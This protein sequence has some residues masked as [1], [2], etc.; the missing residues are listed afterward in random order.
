MDSFASQ[1]TNTLGCLLGT[2]LLAGLVADRFHFPK[3]TAYLLVGLAAGP[4]MLNWLPPDHIHAFDTTT[5]LAMALVLFNLGCHFPLT[6][7]RRV[8]RRSMIMSFGELTATF[9][10][11]LLSL[12]AIGQSWGVALLLASLALA[13]APATTILVLKESASQGPVTEHANTLV[14]LNNLAAIVIFEVVFIAI[15]MAIGDLA[16][17]LSTEIGLLFRDVL[18]SVVLGMAA[19][20]VISFGCGLLSTSRWLVL[21]IAAT[22]VVLGCCE[23]LDMPYMLSF[24]TMGVMVVNSSDISAKIVAELDRLTGLLCV[25]FFCIHGAELDLQAFLAAGFVGAIYIAS[26]SVGKCVGIGVAARAINEPPQVRQWLGP[27]L[28]AQAGAAIAL[29]SIA[30]ERNPQLGEPVRAVILGSVV[31]FEIIGPILIRQGVLRA[32]EVPLAQA[33]YHTTATPISQLVLF[34][35]VSYWCWVETQPIAGRRLN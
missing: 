7:I 24:L 1:I 6:H 8:L 18:G 34:G 29:A 11:V 5:K 33:I 30:V 35:T 9:L 27:A 20:F 22:T 12:L 3:V 32:G 21:L 4:S 15:Q 17:P 14:A 25:I 23:V 31:F 16:N 13:T 10:L 26:R 28:L 2:C 19:G